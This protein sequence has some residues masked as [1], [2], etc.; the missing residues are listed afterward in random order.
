MQRLR[1]SGAT[2][3]SDEM[4]LFEWTRTCC[5][6]QFKVMLELVK[7]RSGINLPI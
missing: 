7:R 3:V 5:H 2:I 6:P 1:E 4:V